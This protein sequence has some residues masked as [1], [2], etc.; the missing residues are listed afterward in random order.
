MRWKGVLEAFALAF[1]YG[2]GFALVSATPAFA[3]RF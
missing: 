1:F 3:H 2:A